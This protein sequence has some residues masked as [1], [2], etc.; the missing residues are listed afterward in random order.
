[1][2]PNTS[3]ETIVGGFLLFGIGIICTLILFFGEVE[4]LF[5]PTYIY[6]YAPRLEGFAPNAFVPTWNAY[7]WRLK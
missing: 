6:A 1:M 4:D 3:T 7:A 2:K 5:N